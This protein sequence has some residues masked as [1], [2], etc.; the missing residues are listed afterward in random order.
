MFT[1]VLGEERNKTTKTNA[2]ILCSHYFV[3]ISGILFFYW[4]SW[5]SLEL[6]SLFVSFIHSF[7]HCRR[8]YSTH[9]CLCL[10]LFAVVAVVVFIVDFLSVYL[11]I[12]CNAFVRLRSHGWGR[13]GFCFRLTTSVDCLLSCTFIYSLLPRSLY[14]HEL[15]FTTYAV[16]FARSLCFVVHA[17]QTQNSNRKPKINTK[18]FS[19]SF[20][21]DVSYIVSPCVFLERAVML[22]SISQVYEDLGKLL[23]AGYSHL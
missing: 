18:L 22:L 14:S 17:V 7:I 12:I 10:V 13:W 8:E 9:L 5:N 1:S 11:S 20:R 6:F 3:F 2:N 21:L 19:F 4:P 16:S 15:F 23:P